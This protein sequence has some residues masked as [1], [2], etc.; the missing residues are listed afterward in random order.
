MALFPM[1]LT[2]IDIE[3][4]AVLSRLSFSDEELVR[5]TRDLN[6]I[7]DYASQIDEIDV[8]G[9]PSFVDV[10]GDR[11]AVRA[12]EVDRLGGAAAREI[13]LKNAPGRTEEYLKVKSVF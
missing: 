7:L 8:K 6:S 12:D 2:K 5:F 1:E 13:F 4:I 10:V 3:K 9:S 11:G